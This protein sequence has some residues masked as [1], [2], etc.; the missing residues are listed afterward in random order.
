MPT[1]NPYHVEVAAERRLLRTHK[2]PPRC[3]DSYKAQALRELAQRLNDAEDAQV[4][5]DRQARLVDLLDC[6]ELKADV[7]GRASLALFM[8]VP[9]AQRLIDA[10]MGRVPPGSVLGIKVETSP[11]V[12]PDSFELRKATGR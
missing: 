3:G 6:A 2:T 10:A 7:E 9:E 11:D 5:K 8:T 4:L 1:W 12:P